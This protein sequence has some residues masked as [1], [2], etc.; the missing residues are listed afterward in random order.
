MFPD[1]AHATTAIDTKYALNINLNQLKYSINQYHL[2][3]KYRDYLKFSRIYF[4]FL[5][6]GHKNT[7]ITTSSRK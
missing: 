2:I 1:I 4:C 3:N 5:N 6:S 7:V